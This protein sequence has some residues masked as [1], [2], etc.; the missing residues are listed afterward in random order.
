[1]IGAVEDGKITAIGH[2]SW[3]GDQPGGG[4][5]VAVMQTRALYAGAH[6]MTAMRLAVLD[7]PEANAMRAPGEAP[8]M[9]ALE[10]AIDE[11]AE[12]LGLDPIEFRIR[13]DTQVAPDNPPPPDSKDPQSKAPKEKHDPHPPFSRRQFVE[14]LR[15]GAERFGWSKRNA[16]PKKTREGHWMIGIGV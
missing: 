1:R 2:E 10:I 15:V 16:A 7:L 13:N 4:P 14:C 11:M 5:E 6:R 12:K 9:M 3:S 8:G